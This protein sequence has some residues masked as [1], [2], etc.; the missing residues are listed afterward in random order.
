MA[1][2]PHTLSPTPPSTKALAQLRVTLAFA[3]TP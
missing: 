1:E 2:A 3:K